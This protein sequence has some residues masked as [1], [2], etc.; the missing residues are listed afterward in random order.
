MLTEKYYFS[1]HKNQSKNFIENNKKKK[2]IIVYLEN[3]SKSNIPN[4]VLMTENSYMIVWLFFVN[5]KNL[6]DLVLHKIL[7]GK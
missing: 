7:T 2:W 4:K 6:V 5:N 3:L 1:K